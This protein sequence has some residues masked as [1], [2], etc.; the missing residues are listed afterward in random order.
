MIDAVARKV[1]QVLGDPVLRYWLLR[2]IA[3]LEKSPSG[4][5]PGQPP[6][7]SAAS[8]PQSTPETDIPAGRFSAPSENVKISLPGETVEL[9]PDDPAALFGRSY[10]DLETLLGAHRFAC[11]PMAGEYL[12]PAW[13]ALLWQS[14]VGGFGEDRSGWPWHAYTAAERA[15][16]II[17][18]SRRFGMPGERDATIALLARHAEI[19]RDGLEYFGDHYTSN[20]L[21]NNGRGLLRIGTALGL[22]NYADTGA[23]IM[24]AEAGRIFG[25]SGALRE[26]S[27]HYHLLVTRNYIDA[28]L[29]ARAGAVDQAVML[30][31]IA[32]RALSVIP[33]LALPGGLP[34]V[35]DISP[36]VTPAYLG[37]LIGLNRPDG[38]P[39]N[40]PASRQRDALSFLREIPPISPDRL[41]DDGWHRFGRNEWQA[42]S[43]VPPDGWPPMPGHGHQDLGSFELHDGTIPVIVDPGRGSYADPRYEDAAVHNGVT[44]D[45]R[46]PM[47]VNRP[48]YADAFRGRVV[49]DRPEMQRT[50]D[51]RLLCNAGF[52]YLKAL[53]SV[54]REWRFTASRV[55]IL[56]RVEGRGKHLVSRRFCTPLSVR[57]DA[58]AAVLSSPSGSYRVSPGVDFRIDELTCW[59]AYGEAVP[60]TQIVCDWHG[61]LPFSGAIEIERL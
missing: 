51:G 20:H 9:T 55:E 4:F 59:S 52:G 2:K 12:D 46:S 32:A 44:I 25:R 13:V 56:D 1:R 38:W 48:Y 61:Q 33:G 19:I 41:A 22:K 10:S 35:G 23:K 24:V 40:L 15:I 54:Q 6:Y 5:V 39:A 11:V 45:G 43:F 27:T 18:F 34:L 28:W 7:L 60:A 57:R 36:D 47:P 37:H 31:E 29:D 58:D 53:S 26:G 8:S 14:W 49:A 17:D 42:L 50:R 16:N 21:S 30:R 3:G